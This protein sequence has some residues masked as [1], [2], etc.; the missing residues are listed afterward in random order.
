MNLT[1]ALQADFILIKPVTT[2]SLFDTLHELLMQGSS[3][4]QIAVADSGKHVME[5]HLEGVKILLAED[6]TMNQIV[7]KGMLE[8]AGASVDIVENGQMAVD[9]LRAAPERYAI[10]LMDVQMPVM[11]GFV[12]TRLI[13]SALGSTVPVLAM[14]AGVTESER[15]QCI[16]AGMDDFIAK[17]IDLGQ[18]FATIARF[19]P[20][21][22][23][24]RVGH[25]DA[26]KRPAAESSL[27]GRTYGARPRSIDRGCGRQCR[28]PGYDPGLVAAHRRPGRSAH[29]RDAPCLA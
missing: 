5:H 4:K 7:A 12:A 13:R 25:R 16:A 17:P 14:T 10:V 21:R 28:L 8:Q 1:D 27:R 23:N 3:G 24:F 2:C 11:D 9:L 22:R 19:L 6:N 20:V 26:R 15:K 18:M 29:R